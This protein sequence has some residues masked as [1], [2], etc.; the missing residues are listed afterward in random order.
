[1]HRVSHREALNARAITRALAACVQV[2]DRIAAGEFYMIT[3]SFRPYV[4]HDFPYEGKE[5]AA[6]RVA[7]ITQ[8]DFERKI[9]NSGALGPYRAVCQLHLDFCVLLSLLSLLQSSPC[10]SA[11]TYTVC[12]GCCPG[13]GA[14]CCVGIVC[15]T[16]R[17]GAFGS[18]LRLQLVAEIPMTRRCQAQQ[19]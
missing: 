17:A 13:G 16:T 18:W 8:P 3:D 1:M 14:H 2:W 9:D 7:A 19:S 10:W 12:V 11:R 4:D 6:S 15:G 5:M